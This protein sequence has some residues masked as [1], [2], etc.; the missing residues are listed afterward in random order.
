MCYLKG[1]KPKNKIGAA[2]GSY[3]WGGGATKSITSEMALMDIEIVEDDL[4]FK[5][6]PQE[7]ELAQCVEFGRKIAAKIKQAE[8]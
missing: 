3:G 6:R 8:L 2:F 7:G 1:L 5:W 4:T